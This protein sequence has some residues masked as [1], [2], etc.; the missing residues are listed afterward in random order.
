MSDDDGPA[1]S[2]AWMATFADLMSLLMCFFVLLLSFAEMD[3][4]K[5]KQIAGSMKVAFGVQNEF[6]LEDIPK[7]TSV[8]ATEFSPGETSDTIVDTIQQVTDQT[9]DPS[10]RVGEG[11]LEDSEAEELLQQKITAL[12]AETEADADKLKDMLEDEVQ[13]GKVDVE[14]DGR[15]I[16]VRIREQGSFPSGSA[17]L[18]TD[19]VPVMARI[20]E[21]L[22]EIPGTISIEGHTDSTPLRGG[23]YESNWGLSSS[24][25]LS[26]THELLREGLLKDDR[27]MVVGFAD[28]RPFTF[29]DTV[30]GRASNR[31]VEIVIRQGIEDAEESELKSIRDI[32]PDALDILGIE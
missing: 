1:G 3:V 13:T 14:S 4:Q 24:R 22:T 32:N 2:P 23:R 19:F 11:E 27:M 25:A 31:R 28:T 12:L 26:V 17:T 18:N 20:R 21:A 15:T 7:G 9:T 29:N 8:V 16:T 10:L 30:E 5:F 6:E